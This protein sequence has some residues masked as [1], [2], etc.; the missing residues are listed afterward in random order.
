MASC[1]WAGSI[2]GGGFHAGEIL[3]TGF[4]V[5]PKVFF[6]GD[7]SVGMVTKVRDVR[8]CTGNRGAKEEMGS[9]ESKVLLVIG[10]EGEAEWC[11][12]TVRGEVHVMD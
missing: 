9:S 6:V 5:E 12:C 1:A 8:L 10:G 7:W 11:G 2:A 3:F 4:T